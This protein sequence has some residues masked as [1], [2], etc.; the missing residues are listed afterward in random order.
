M[1]SLIQTR[2]ETETGM[3]TIQK[4]P[5]DWEA[6]RDDANL[7]RMEESG[8]K[9]KGQEKEENKENARILS[10]RIHQISMHGESQLC[11]VLLPLYFDFLF[12]SRSVTIIPS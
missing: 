7:K 6:I 9:A 2:E 5:N 11:H 12:R 4:E 10:M 8:R 3:S 1:W